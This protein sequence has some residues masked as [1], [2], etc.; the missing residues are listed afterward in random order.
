MFFI[1]IQKY[2]KKLVRK[3]RET[4]SVAA[5]P[6]DLN[7]DI[8]AKVFLTEKHVLIALKQIIITDKK[9]A[10]SDANRVIT[11]NATDISLAVSNIT[12]DKFVTSFVTT[13][14][15]GDEKLDIIT[16]IS[17][18]TWEAVFKY[19][20]NDPANEQFHART[21]VVGYGENYSF[22]CGDLYIESFNREIRLIGFQYQP[23]FEPAADLNLDTRKFST[24]YSDC[25]GYFTP[26]IWGALFIVI[27]LMSIMTYGISMM[28]DIRTMDKFDDP[29]GKTITVSTAE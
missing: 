3:T 29:K 23:S 8:P 26:G 15:K 6:Q 16:S 12:E 20:D 7:P 5:A 22:G 1:Q 27:L 28:M 4:E 10:A 14:S 18:G 25:V 19:K 17:A 2:S 13:L 24:R 9:A 21:A 11:I